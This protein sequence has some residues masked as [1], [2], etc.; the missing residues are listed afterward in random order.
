MLHGIIFDAVLLLRHLEAYRSLLCHHLS[1]D[2]FA[3]I[4]SHLQL[5]LLK[6]YP[7]TA[8][9]PALSPLLP[10][11][12]SL[13][14]TFFLAST[15]KY[16][17]SAIA[18]AHASACFGSQFYVNLRSCP[19]HLLYVHSQ[20]TPLLSRLTS[21]LASAVN[22]LLSCHLTFP[23]NLA[24]LPNIALRSNSTCTFLY[25]ASSQT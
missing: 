6:I 7:I 2:R 8:V 15:P 13:D 3:L 19:G 24:I 20:D 11:L 5:L 25:F 16:N 23:L 17:N 1:L 4:C 9:T 18:S 10:P 14:L 12:L 21:D 22:L